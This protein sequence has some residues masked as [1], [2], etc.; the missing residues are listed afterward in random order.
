MKAI[1]VKKAGGPEVL[2]LV[3]LPKPET[4]AGWSLV[5]IKGFGIN[6]SEIFTRQ[7]HSPSV[8]FPRVLGIECVGIIE[9]TTDEQRLPVGQKVLS[10]MGEMGRAFDGSYAE[11]V[12]LPNEQI[13]PVATDLSWS[14]FA[15]VPESYFTAYGSMLQLRLEDGDKVLVRGAAS[16]VG[17]AFTKL[18]KAAHPDMRVVGSVRNLKKEAQLLAAGYDQIILEEDGLLQTQEVFDKVLE[19]V[20]PSVIKDSIAHMAPYGIICNTGLLGGQWY[21][22]DFEPT[23]D[24]SK[25]IYL[26]T[27]YSGNVSAEGWQSLFDYIAKYGVKVSPDKIFS[28]ESIQEA[29]AFLEGPDALGKVVVMNE[30]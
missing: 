26:T 24:L 17:L 13:F 9:E 15:A 2:D 28:L 3:S 7:G 20:G 18:V 4:K 19:L 1:L 29:H 5:K 8:S 10:T 12:L 22:E 11:Y 21:L 27:F 23:F 25:N 14:D 30:D 16:G 6:R